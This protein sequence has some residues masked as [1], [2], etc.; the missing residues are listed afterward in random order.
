[1]VN[2]TT[3]QAHRSSSRTESFDMTFA[4]L[5]PAVRPDIRT[6]CRQPHAPDVP[7]GPIEV[8]WANDC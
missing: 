7:P 4:S 2:A 1:M 6:R 8:E 5:L 3:R